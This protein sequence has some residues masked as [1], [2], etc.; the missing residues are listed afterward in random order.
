MSFCYSS[1]SESQNR[2]SSQVSCKYPGGNALFAA[3]NS[4]G[5]GITGARSGLIVVRLS[6]FTLHGEQ[7]ATTFSHD[8]TPPMLLG[9]T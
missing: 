5:V 6:F 3:T 9:T 7:Q 1:N 2:K 8:V 4:C